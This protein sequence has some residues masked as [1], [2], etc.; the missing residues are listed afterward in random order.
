MV[1]TSMHS[2]RYDTHT[3][4][5]T[6]MVK[7]IVDEFVRKLHTQQGSVCVRVLSQQLCSAAWLIFNT[8]LAHTHINTHK[9]LQWTL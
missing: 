6:R 1:Q 9:D 3:R 4:A 8:H 2:L 5:H 7:S